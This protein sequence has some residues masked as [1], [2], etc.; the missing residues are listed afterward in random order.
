MSEIPGGSLA[1]EEI[2]KAVITRGYSQKE[3]SEFLGV[4]YSTM[5]RKVNKTHNARNNTRLGS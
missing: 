4:H 3:V 1:P 5:S 2:R